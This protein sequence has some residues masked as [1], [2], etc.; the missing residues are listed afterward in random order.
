MDIPKTGNAFP[1]N[2]RPIP[3]INSYPKPDFKQNTAASVQEALHE[4]DPT[5]IL[6]REFYPAAAVFLNNFKLD[7][8]YLRWFYEGLKNSKKITNVHGYFFKVFFRDVYA[9]R[10]KAFCD[11]QNKQKDIAHG[12]ELIYDCPVCQKRQHVGKET[13]RCESC[14]TPINPTQE[15]IK[16]FR[17]LF[18]MDEATKERYIFARSKVTRSGGNVT[19]NLAELDKQFGI[20]S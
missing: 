13:I 10:Y 9:A 6:D 3:D 19:A 20:V 4:I 7:K 5:L 2:G 15:E 11:E 8:K 1:E 17:K 18:V 14:G 16:K 12:Q